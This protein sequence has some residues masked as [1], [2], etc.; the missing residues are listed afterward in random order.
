MVSALVFLCT[1]FAGSLAFHRGY[2]ASASRRAMLRRWRWRGEVVRVEKAQA[3]HRTA[4]PCRRST[5]PFPR[6]HAPWRSNGAVVNARTWI[7][8]MCVSPCR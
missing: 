6:I 1:C 8:F 3:T 2:L 7:C 5:L 4:V